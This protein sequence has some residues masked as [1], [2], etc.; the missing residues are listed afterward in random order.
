MDKK[1]K[2]KGPQ[3][4]NHTLARLYD[5]TVEQLKQAFTYNE[6][7]LMFDVMNG[8]WLTSG[9]TGQHAISNV[10]ASYHEYPGMYED[11]WN[12]KREELVAKLEK[13]NLGQ[14]GILEIYCARFWE[15][16]SGSGGTAFDAREYTMP[17]K[18]TLQ[19]QHNEAMKSLDESIKRMEESRNAVKSKTIAQARTEAEKAR[20]LLEQLL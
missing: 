6:F 16:V 20:A 3:K 10:T 7:M 14:L 13:L 15:N 9:I 17:G 8:T 11:K 1:A 18:H 2:T 19:A 5:E 4:M 12:V